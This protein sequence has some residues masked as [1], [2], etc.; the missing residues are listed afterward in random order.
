MSADERMERYG[1]SAEPAEVVERGTGK[2][3]DLD[4][5][6][7]SLDQAD[8]HSSSDEDEATE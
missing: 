7:A 2:T 5:H 4:E 6:L 8:G 1:W 3:I